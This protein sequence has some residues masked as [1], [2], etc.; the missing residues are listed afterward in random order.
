MRSAQSLSYTQ[1]TEEAGEDINVH[2]CPYLDMQNWMTH[3][4]P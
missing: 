2:M 1:T 4:G 3:F